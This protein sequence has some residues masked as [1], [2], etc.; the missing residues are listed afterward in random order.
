MAAFVSSVLSAFVVH[1]F[2]GWEIVEQRDDGGDEA[3]HAT[4]TGEAAG[5][6]SVPSGR[7]AC[8][9]R[10]TCFQRQSSLIQVA[11][12]PSTNRRMDIAKLAFHL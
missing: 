4:R 1:L 11:T 5:H 9:L 7:C 12:A 10:R 6:W 8:C 3:T 2:Q